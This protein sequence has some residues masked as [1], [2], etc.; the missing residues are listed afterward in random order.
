MQQ[1]TTTTAMPAA[2]K[3]KNDFNGDGYS[4][5]LLKNAVNSLYVM[6]GKS[7]G[8]VGLPARIY[9]KDSISIYSAVATGDFNGDGYSDI[10][11]KNETGSLYVMQGNSD[12][13]LASPVRIYKESYSPAT[14]S[15]VGTGDFNG[16]G[17][18]DILLKNATGSLYVMHENSDGTV[19]SPA[20]IYKQ[21]SPATYSVVG[22]GDFDGDG[23][24]DILLENSTGSLFVMQGNSDGTVDLPACIYTESTPATYSVVETADFNGDGT[25]DILLKN[26]AGSLYVMQGKSDGTF[27]LPACIYTEST[28][29][30]YSVVGTG[31]FNGDGTTAILLENVGGSLYVLHENSDGTVDPPAC[32][33]TESTPA[34]YSVVGT[35]DLNGDGTTD[36][37]LKDA[38]GLMYVMQ[39]NSDG[40]LALP[41]RIYN[42]ST[43][44]DFS[45]VGTG[46]FNGDGTT[47][48][49]LKKDINGSLYVLHENSD[50]T[51][52]LPTRI[53][54]ESSPATYSVVATGDFNGDTY[55]DILLKNAAGSL[56][57]LHGNSDGTVGL[58]VRIYKESYSP[59]T[60]SVVGTGDF[61]GD[62]ITEILLKNAG[63][64]LYVMHENSDGT[65]ATSA[66]IY[67]ESTPA[68]YSVVGTG[69]FNGDTYCD[70]LL[71][72][73][74]GSLYVLQGKSDGTVGLPAR[75]YKESTPATY[76]VVGT[77]DFNGDGTT[78]IL[79]KNAAGSL[80]VMQG[81]SDGTV[82]LP[83]RIYKESTPASYSI[84]AY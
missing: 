5:I 20:R 55:C 84:V 71:K 47:D 34:T 36:I 69:D 56:Y 44:V 52:A 9:K 72:N 70:I 48:I 58:P 62:G 75:I 68:T 78:D 13:T 33:Y 74:N 10:L 59:A 16:D 79:L 32:I 15:V 76:S 27:D 30:T 41:A 49:L 28:P 38:A 8:T 43:P 46:D 1:S 12:G 25:T 57:V 82:A 4:D 11:L 2:G 45:V 53:Y 51:L 21:S 42:Q 67:K 73:A 54:K 83:A 18:T 17:T 6:H 64:S 50:G 35:E 14:Y 31:D 19:S 39:G 37:L 61:N 3:F 26:A 40:T 63:G 24:T 81:K 66:R 7:D 22:T 29:A 80:Y 60:Y 65:L 77:A 23:T